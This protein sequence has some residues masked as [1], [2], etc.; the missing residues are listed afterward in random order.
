MG[1]HFYDKELIRLA[2]ER[3]DIPYEELQKVDE[4]RANPW[5]YPVDEKIQMENRFRFL[6]DE[7]HAFRYREENH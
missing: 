3:S 4:Q 1:V 5:R 7:R 6:S 2:S